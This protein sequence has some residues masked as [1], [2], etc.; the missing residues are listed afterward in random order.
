M[1]ILNKLDTLD[2]IQDGEIN[3]VHRVYRSVTGTTAVTSSPYS[4]AKW[5]V[6][7]SNVTAY[8]DGMI[9]DIKVPV[10]GNSSYGTVLQINELGYKPVV[11]NVNSMI[12][13]RYSVNSHIFAVYNATQTAT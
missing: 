3:K 7:D 13:T 5:Q 4:A 9:I 6:T 10:A 11:Y 12:G 2:N 8:T 1:K